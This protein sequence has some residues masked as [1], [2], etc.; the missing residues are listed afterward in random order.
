MAL[1]GRLALVAGCSPRSWAGRA[2]PE[3]ETPRM[4]LLLDTDIG[5]DIDDAVALA[6]LLANPKQTYWGLQP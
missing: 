4:T 1:A 6:Y 5:S 3:A 2:N